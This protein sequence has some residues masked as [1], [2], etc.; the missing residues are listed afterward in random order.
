MCVPTDLFEFKADWIYIVTSM[1]AWTPKLLSVSKL[2][3]VSDS[4]FII[5]T[6]VFVNGDVFCSSRDPQP[7]EDS[8]FVL[9]PPSVSAF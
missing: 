5:V 8:R 1:P 7:Q 6:I 2:S 4:C 3:E 9:P